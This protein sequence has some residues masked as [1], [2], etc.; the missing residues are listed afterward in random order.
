MNNLEEYIF[1]LEEDLKSIPELSEIELIRY[2]YLNLGSRMSF[3]ETFRPF[4][5]SKTR[6][7][8]YKYHSRSEKD[9]EK[10]MKNNKV[11]CKSL[12]YILE[13]VLKRFGVDIKTIVDYDDR[14]NCPH[15]YNYINQK[16]GI[17]YVVDLQED[18]YNIQA[19]YL[20]KNFGINSIKEMKYIISRFDQEQIDRKLGYI[21]NDNYYADEYLYLLR[22]TSD[23][24]DNFGDKVKFIL[25]NIDMYSIENMGYIDLQWHHKTILEYFFDK[26]DFS[27]DDSTGIIR[28]IDC[29]KYVNGVRKY[30]N[31]IAIQNKGET[32]IYLYNRKKSR[33]SK[34]NIDYFANAVK[35]GLIIH[36]C[37][38]PGL[39]KVL[40]KNL[41]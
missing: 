8:M 14:S 3:D 9:L 17:S 34:I 24:I 26:K 35:N 1:E 40:K 41:N 30:I 7:N 22:L 25:E 38:V 31:C 13:Y 10:C 16:N 15:V 33:Y 19:H 18:L 39:R 12:S 5:N 4:G 36:N 27:Y 28:M 6:Q 20:P 29:Y 11:I 21:S 2:V 37:S 23:F 32:E